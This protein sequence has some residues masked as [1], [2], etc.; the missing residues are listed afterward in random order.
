[1]VSIEDYVND[2]KYMISSF[3]INKLDHEIQVIVREHNEA[4]KSIPKVINGY[5]III[6]KTLA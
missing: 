1:M 4:Q 3:R 6:L 5:T 2:L